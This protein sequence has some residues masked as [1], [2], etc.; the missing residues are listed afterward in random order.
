MAVDPLEGLAAKKFSSILHFAVQ[1]WF[2]STLLVEGRSQP[3]QVRRYVMDENA[4]Y[5]EMYLKLFRVPEEAVNIPIAAQR[6]CEELY[7]SPPEPD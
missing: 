7:L 1:K 2:V 4:D 5:K 3:S 6:E